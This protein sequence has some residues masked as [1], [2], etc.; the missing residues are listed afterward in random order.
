MSI[1]DFAS[2]AQIAMP[3]VATPAVGGSLGSSLVSAARGGAKPFR[4][5]GLAMRFK[6]NV[7]G[8]GEGL[9]L[10]HWTSCEGLKVE[11]KYEPVR[12]GGDYSHTQVLPQYVSY[13]PITL[14]RAIEK[15]YSET[16]EMWLRQVAAQWQGA[17]DISAIG[18]TVTI[19][20][21]DVYQD[22]DN[23][24]YSWELINAF[25][26]A[27][28]GPS[29]SAKSGEIATETLVLEHDGFLESTP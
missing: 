11:F 2:A 17:C 14:K 25:P 7:I 10:G 3:Q 24:A 1:S 8:L 28:S 9:N 18:K 5:L 15:P 26:I 19:D 23:P 16:V 27:W 29:L 12:A 21:L 22:P 6:V 13:S 4:N 20:L